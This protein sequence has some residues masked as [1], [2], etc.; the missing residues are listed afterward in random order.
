LSVKNEQSA[1]QTI[2]KMFI[3]TPFYIT[4]PR[5]TALCWW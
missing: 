4:E 5:P 2:T 1:A 3:L